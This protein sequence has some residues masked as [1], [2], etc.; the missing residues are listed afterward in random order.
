MSRIV[1]LTL[2]PKSKSP[3]PG[4]PLQTDPVDD[5]LNPGLPSVLIVGDSTAQNKLDL[6]WADHFARS[7]DTTRVKVSNRARAGRSSRT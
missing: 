2:Q 1:L 7:F 3:P 5:P 4:V 6:G